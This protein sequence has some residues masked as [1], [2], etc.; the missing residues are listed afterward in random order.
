MK[1]MNKQAEGVAELDK[2]TVITSVQQLKDY[3]REH[4]DEKTV[5]SI[6]SD[7]IIAAGGAVDEGDA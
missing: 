6:V 3:L 2:E 5:I 7:H 4:S 1:K